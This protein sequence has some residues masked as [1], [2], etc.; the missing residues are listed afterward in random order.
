MI[1][2][3]EKPF[4]KEKEEVLSKLKQEM[5]ERERKIPLK[6]SLQLSYD[7]APCFSLEGENGLFVSV[8]GTQPVEKAKEKILSR[9]QIEKQMKKMGNTEF[10]LEG[11]SI[12]GEEDIFY[13]LSFLNQLR[14]DGVEKMREAIL[15]QYRRHQRLRGN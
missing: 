5:E 14:R 7:K 3:G 9:E 10:S 8:E 6:G 15:G 2:F 4:R 12:L 13:P 11:L 1:V